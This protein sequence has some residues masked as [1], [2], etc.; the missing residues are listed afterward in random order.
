MSISGAPG[1]VP[2]HQPGRG[3][4]REML[5]GPNLCK[6]SRVEI[7]GRKVFASNDM[8]TALQGFLIDAAFLASL[9]S[10]GVAAL[11]ALKPVEDSER[12]LSGQVQMHVLGKLHNVRMRIQY[13]PDPRDPVEWHDVVAPQV[14]VVERLPVPMHVSDGPVGRNV[15]WSSGGEPRHKAATYGEPFSSH[16]YWGSPV[17]IAPL[18]FGPTDGYVGEVA[19][20][21]SSARGPIDRVDVNGPNRQSALAVCIV[22]P[23]GIDDASRDKVLGAVVKVLATKGFSVEVSPS[24]PDVFILSAESAPRIE[25]L[26]HPALPHRI[27]GVDVVFREQ[28]PPGGSS[29]VCIVLPNGIDDASRDKVLGA[30]VKVPTTSLVEWVKCGKYGEKRCRNGDTCT[31]VSC[32]FAHPTT[33]QHLKHPTRP[34]LRPP[35][36]ASPERPWKGKA[37]TP[38]AYT[39]ADGQLRELDA[40]HFCA[41][42]ALL[43]HK[44]SGN[45]HAL[46]AIEE[47]T[48]NSR[49]EKRY[50]FLGGKRDSIHESTRHVEMLSAC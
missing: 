19:S 27:K 24:S 34:D 50:N 42:G 31:N 11:Q 35:G 6:P 40:K 36:H 8:G 4:V 45:P 43:W 22:L 26:L 5:Y 41:A 46:L 13:N 25:E 7:D 38:D 3:H 30:V 14:F 49:V 17:A 2:P 9:P 37:V 48:N 29:A 39:A 18:A 32:A 47:R 10:Y 12:V 23:N 1:N 33:W 15:G 20:E 16:P 28:A 21:R 44:K